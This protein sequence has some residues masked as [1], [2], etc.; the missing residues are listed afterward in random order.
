MK[1]RIIDGE[2]VSDVQVLH[3]NAGYYIGREYLDKDFGTWMPYDRL[4]VEYYPTR[5]DAKIALAT[6]AYTPRG[7]LS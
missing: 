4:S 1:T 2:T 6:H 7:Y 3:S 5:D